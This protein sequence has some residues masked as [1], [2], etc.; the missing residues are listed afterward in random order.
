MARAPSRLRG[1]LLLLTGLALG[2]AGGLGAAWVAHE[3][4][5]PK[6]PPCR[7]SAPFRAMQAH[8]GPV[9]LLIGNSQVFDGDWR[10]GDALAVNCGRQG[11]LAAEGLAAAPALPGIDPDAVLVGF[12]AVEALR[13]A[14][15]AA[16]AQDYDALLERLRAR[17]PDARIIA[18]TVPPM[19]ADAPDLPGTAPRAAAAAPAFST[20]IRAAA[21]A[22][23][24]A[25]LD[26]GAALGIGDAPPPAA[27]SHDGVHLSAA[28]YAALSRALGAMIAP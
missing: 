6:A 18:M 23:G 26:A 25:I 5:S 16:F 7:P 22:H 20:E 15:A 10:P 11:M 1:P 4:L 14:D 13:G 8:D 28:G 3:R 21:A 12:G 2:G 19:R 17:W 9:A 24:I 27:L